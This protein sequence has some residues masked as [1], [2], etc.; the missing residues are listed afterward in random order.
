MIHH[1]K[2]HN[3]CLPYS[4]NE[5]L[6]GL[7]LVE[8]APGHLSLSDDGR[9]YEAGMTISDEYAHNQYTLFWDYA[10]ALHFEVPIFY[11]GEQFFCT[12]IDMPCAGATLIDLARDV[13]EKHGFENPLLRI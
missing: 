9:L 5:T 6:D 7:H 3:F 13:V 8:I 10:N 4:I 1:L 2:T 12:V 11:D